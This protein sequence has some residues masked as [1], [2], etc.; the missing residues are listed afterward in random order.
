[1]ILEDT[2]ERRMCVDNTNNNNMY[3]YSSIPLGC[4]V[5]R[6]D[7]VVL[8]GKLTAEQNDDSTEVSLEELEE[9]IMRQQSKQNE[10]LMTSTKNWDFDRDLEA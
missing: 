9:I 1:M 2:S 4:Y 3:Y 6:G 10:E 8:L 7:N 5:V